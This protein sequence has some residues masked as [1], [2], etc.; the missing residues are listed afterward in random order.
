MNMPVRESGHHHRILKAV[1]KM[2]TPFLQK[3]HFPIYVLSLPG[4]PDVS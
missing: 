1:S 3:T 2:L 4:T